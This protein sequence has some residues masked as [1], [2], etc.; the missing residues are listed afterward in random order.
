M[1]SLTNPDNPDAVA[2]NDT[3]INTYITDI[4]SDF[5][6]YVHINLNT[7]NID[8][9]MISTACLGLYCKIVQ[10]MGTNS[11]I[12]EFPQYYKNLQALYE[13]MPREMMV[14]K[15]RDRYPEQLTDVQQAQANVHPGVFIFGTAAASGTAVTGTNTKWLTAPQRV[16]PNYAIAFGHSEAVLFKASDW[17]I[18]T[19]V[20]SDTSLTLDRSAGTVA[21]GPYVIQLADMRNVYA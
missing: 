21:A 5:W 7:D 2:I 3:V 14:N 6:I 17:Y 9:R 1:I 18:I 8:P 4:V 11:E 10:G 15:M 13:T 20:N 19:A 12:K 16:L